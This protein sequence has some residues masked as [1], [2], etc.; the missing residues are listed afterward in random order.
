MNMHLTPLESNFVLTSFGTWTNVT[1][2]KTPKWFMEGLYP[3]Q[4][5]FGVMLEIAMERIWFWIYVV[6]ATISTQNLQLN[7]ICCN[8]HHTHSTSVWFFLSTTSFY[9]NVYGVVVCFTMPF[10]LKNVLN[11]F[12]LYPTSITFDYLDFRV[13]LQL[14][15]AS[16]PT[17]S[18][19]LKLSF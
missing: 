13:H 11:F 6:V 18:N 3:H 16:L 1:Q 17:I 12:K 5:S 4:A 19:I 2:P 8:I 7:F 15:F 14:P 10:S 9:F